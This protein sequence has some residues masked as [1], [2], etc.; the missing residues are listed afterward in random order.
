MKTSV[1][2]I[3]QIFALSAEARLWKKTLRDLQDEKQ[4]EDGSDPSN[5]RIIGGFVASNDRFSYTVSLQDLFG[6]HFCGGSL[7]A[8]DMV[9]SAAHCGGGSVNVIIARDVLTD[10]D[11]ESIDV[12]QKN[13]HPGYDKNSNEN[14]NDFLVLKLARSTTANAVPVKLNPSSSIPSDGADVTVV[15]WG[16]TNENSNSVSNNLMEVEVTSSSNSDCAASYGFSMITDAMLCAADPSQDSCQGDSGGPLVLKGNTAGDDVQVG[17]VSW[18]YGCADPNYPGVYARVSS[19]YSF[20]KEMVCEQ[21]SDQ[22]AR[23]SFGCESSGITSIGSTSATSSTSSS[24][25]SNTGTNF[26]TFGPL[27]PASSGSG[28]TETI[29]D[30]GD[31]VFPKTDEA[32]FWQSFEDIWNS[33]WGN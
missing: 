19:G 12:A 21:S 8:K 16:V 1:L 5:T 24:S 7:I 9:L 6:N 30:M 29:I 23:N 27:G 17:V 31:D 4:S 11:G 14:N 25:G 22:D 3:A 18:G 26:P 2:L 13:F 33:F 32:S 10:S 20:I 15:G 28:P